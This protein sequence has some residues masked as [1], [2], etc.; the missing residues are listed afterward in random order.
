MVSYFGKDIKL[1]NVMTYFCLKR[2]IKEREMG[3]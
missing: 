3:Y 2:L 1:R